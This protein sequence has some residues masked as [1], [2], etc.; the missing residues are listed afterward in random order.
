[1]ENN[2][3]FFNWFK[4]KVVKKIE[5]YTPSDAE[6]LSWYRDGIQSLYRLE[7]DKPVSNFKPENIQA[8]FE[9]VFRTAKSSICIYDEKLAG[10]HFN[11]PIL[12]GFLAYAL[13]KGI[14]VDVVV[15]DVPT[16][17]KVLDVLREYHVPVY[18]SD[19]KQD[20]MCDEI[21]IMDDTSLRVK[22]DGSPGFGVMYDKKIVEGWQRFFGIL[23]GDAILKKSIV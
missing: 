2:M 12:A 5:E 18:K 3:K 8:F 19:W 21:L 9:F 17:S 23:I 20:G 14:R 7:S 22:Q 11:N 1:M 16:P 4:K 13:K 10:K 6:V 15:K